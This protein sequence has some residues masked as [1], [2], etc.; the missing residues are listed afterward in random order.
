MECKL[1]AQISPASLENVS[2][3]G[4]EKVGE[5]DVPPESFDGNSSGSD[6]SLDEEFGIPSL[7]TQ[8][9]KRHKQ[10]TRHQEVIQ[11]FVDLEE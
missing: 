9:V 6:M 2:R 5:P 8:D 4:K 10:V 3:K 1:R 7:K 11:K